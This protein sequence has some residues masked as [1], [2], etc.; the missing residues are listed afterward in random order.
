MYHFDMESQLG[1][2]KEPECKDDPEYKRDH[3]PGPYVANVMCAA[4]QN[5]EYRSAFWTGTNLQMTLMTIPVGGEIGLEIHPD[6][7]QMIRVEEGQ[8]VARI[9]NHKG[10][11]E[12]EQYLGIN[13]VVF[14]PE[15]TWHN[16]VNTGRYALKLSSIYGPPKHPKGTVEHTKADAEKKAYGK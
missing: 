7:D 10:Q 4:R 1:Y 15:G 9:G 3:G 13:D 5:K 16:I 11:L 2:G 8:G 12:F 6:T 14:V